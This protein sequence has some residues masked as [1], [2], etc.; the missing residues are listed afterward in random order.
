M[1]IYL[2]SF[3]KRK[4]STAVP[5]GDGTT[6][7]CVLKEATSYKNPSF[8]LQD[9]PDR[10][11]NY[12]KWEDAYYWINDI[13]YETN[14][15]W[16]ISC[17][18]DILGTYRSEI[19]ATRCFIEY[20]SGGN[21]RLVDPRLAKCVN[22]SETSATA[23]LPASLIDQYGCVIAN[24]TGLNCSGPVGFIGG[25]L[26]ASALREVLNDAYNWY[27]Q[28]SGFDVS[29]VESAIK[30]LGNIAF[31]GSAADNLHNAYWVP[32]LPTF[33][34]SRNLFLGLY[35]TGLTCYLL[36]V[37]ETF[38]TG[39]TISVP[40]APNVYQRNS[41]YSDYNLYIPFIGNVSLSADILADEASLTLEFSCAP[42]T[43]DFTCLVRTA[44]GKVLGTYGTTLRMEIPLSSA[45]VSAG[46]LAN[47]I[48]SAAG[49]IR[50][51]ASAGAEIGGVVGGVVGGVAGATGALMG[52]EG[53]T[54]SIGGLG[55]IASWNLSQLIKLTCSYWDYS[56]S[57]SNLSP[58]IGNPLFK[59][60][61]I[62]N[63]T[64]VKTGAGSVSS[65]A[66]GSSINEINSLLSGGV[67]IE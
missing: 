46:N 31:S 5:S 27:D 21:S 8:L 20:G 9:K 62:S 45:G 2:Y 43:G 37:A 13:T 49:A 24:V 51:G 42:V 58:I 1:N 12:V 50:A 41:Q 11:V 30:S 66:Y 18:M 67:Y 56:D 3:S 60:D 36:N 7:S 63:H 6:V 35:D 14:N 47:T 29:S 57:Y 10:S 59:V 28:V 22:A 23:A 48:S 52:I 53:S 39:A 61:T 25:T 16:R 15:L 33:G 40:K 38:G 54:S 55:S 32:M 44:S 26:A 19:S 34:S 65:G 4:N 17:S 64:Y